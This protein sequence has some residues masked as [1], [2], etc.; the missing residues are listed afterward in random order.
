MRSSTR[1]RLA[2]CFA[3]SACEGAALCAAFEAWRS[4][5]T[6]V[7]TEQQPG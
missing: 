1:A 7:V 2:L 4:A 3:V 6:F 5:K